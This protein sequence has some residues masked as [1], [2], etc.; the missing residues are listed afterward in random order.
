[1]TPE[2]I[3]LEV[4]IAGT[5]LPAIALASNTDFLGEMWKLKQRRLAAAVTKCSACS[6]SLSNVKYKLGSS[7]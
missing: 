7:F 6:S 1:M 5:M 4:A 3:A 2:I